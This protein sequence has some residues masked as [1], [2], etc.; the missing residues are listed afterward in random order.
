M[1]YL[2]ALK[3]FWGADIGSRPLLF[4][5]ILLAMAGIQLV[6]TGVLAEIQTRAVPA[7]AYPVRNPLPLQERVWQGQP[8]LQ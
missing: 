2:L 5:G 3:I 7:K 4:T 8:P 1:G 6:T